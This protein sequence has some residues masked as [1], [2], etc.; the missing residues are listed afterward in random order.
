MLPDSDQHQAITRFTSGRSRFAASSQ[1]YMHAVVDA[2][3][4]LYGE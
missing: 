4:D 1:S 2:G 3:W